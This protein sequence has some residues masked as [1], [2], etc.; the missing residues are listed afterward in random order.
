[1][2]NDQ[3]AKSLWFISSTFKLTGNVTV[4]KNAMCLKKGY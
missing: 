4:N 2:L 1:M 3:N